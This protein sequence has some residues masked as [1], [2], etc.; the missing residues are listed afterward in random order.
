MS[1]WQ[2][3]V[4]LIALPILFLLLFGR[5]LF[6]SPSGFLR[7]Y[8]WLVLANTILDAWLTS[9]LGVEA[10][11]LSKSSASALAIFFVIAG[12][13]RVF[14]LAFQQS[15]RPM[16]AWIW[17]SVVALSLFGPLV[18][19]GLILTFPNLFS[20]VRL[21]FLAYEVVLAAVLASALLAWA[22][23]GLCKESVHPLAREVLLYALATYGWWI[24]ADVVIL[25]GF[26]VGYLL[27]VVPNLLYYG[28][29]VPFV[30]FR[31][32]AH[33]LVHGSLPTSSPRV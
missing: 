19:A 33:G 21:T 13:F 4:L 31:A 28:A 3:P 32:Q 23:W 27:R 22:R 16:T 11:G 15:A 18:Q 7:N 2:Q 14:I 24:L 8:L 12:D 6:R 17:T 1:F 5:K 30:Y 26:D 25:A 9:N 10:L 29:Y 20:D